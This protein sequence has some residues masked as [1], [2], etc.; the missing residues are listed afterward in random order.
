MTV[1][2]ATNFKLW[3]FWGS[4]AIK[5]VPSQM[6]LIGAERRE[7]MPPGS[8]LYRDFDLHIEKQI[9]IF[10]IYKLSCYH[11]ILFSPDHHPPSEAIF[12][13]SFVLRMQKK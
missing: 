12:E 6:A 9:L 4:D 13:Q 11:R 10:L 8:Y 2:N 7:A 5:R 3:R 1:C